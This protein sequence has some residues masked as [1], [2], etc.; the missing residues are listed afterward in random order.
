MFSHKKVEQIRTIQ[1]AFNCCGL[2]N[3]RDMAW[4]FPD[5]THDA[6]SCE[7]MFGHSNGC[8][9][10]W[11]GEEQRMAGLLMGMVGLVFIWQ[12]SLFAST[13]HSSR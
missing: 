7:T 11:K 13:L 10:A 4:P 6:R 5:K 9:G 1:D 8:L 2:K 12:V 3:S